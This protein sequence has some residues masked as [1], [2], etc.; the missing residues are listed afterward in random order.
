MNGSR[1][2]ELSLQAR[3][4]PTGNGRCQPKRIEPNP[5]KQSPSQ[6]GA[7]QVAGVALEFSDILLLAIT[8]GVGLPCAGH[9]G[10]PG[11]KGKR[12]GIIS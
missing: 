9:T 3:A 7:S 11:G 6:T 1:M 8:A 12:W 5:E 10:M 4:T 2:A